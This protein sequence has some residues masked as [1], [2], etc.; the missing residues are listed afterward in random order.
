M[1]SRNA[2]LVDIVR[3]KIGRVLVLDSIQNGNFWRT[4]DV[5]VFDTWHWW[6]HTG[7][8]QPYVRLHI[9]SYILHE[10]AKEN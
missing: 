7:R 10:V 3:E 5:L 8:K 2:Y 1:L 4:F 6:L 9:H